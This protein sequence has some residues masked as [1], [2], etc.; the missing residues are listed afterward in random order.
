VG[1]ILLRLDKLVKK[2]DIFCNASSGLNNLS[3]LFSKF[4]QPPQ[5]KQNNEI[6]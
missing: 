2:E 4:K 5:E 3:D 6:I 1:Y